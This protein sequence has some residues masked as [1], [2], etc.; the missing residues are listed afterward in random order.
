MLAYVE[1]LTL[2]PGAVTEDDVAALRRA[3]FDD[4][5]ILDICEVTAYYAYVN[6]IA[7]GLGVQLE[8]WLPDDA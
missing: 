6:R 5:D 8:T 3:G 7:D 1:K 2:R 4:R